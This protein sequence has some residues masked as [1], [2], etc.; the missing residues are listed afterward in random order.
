MKKIKNKKVS[1][2]DRL[3]DEAL[4]GEHSKWY[5]FYVKYKGYNFLREKTNTIFTKGEF[6]DHF[7]RLALISINEVNKDNLLPPPGFKLIDNPNYLEWVA[8]EK[9]KK[10]KLN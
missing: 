5:Y 2:E 1:K 8:E 6:W 3:W 9:A 7:R 4:K 10:N